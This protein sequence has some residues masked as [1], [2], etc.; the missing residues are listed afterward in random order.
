MCRS[1]FIPLC[2]YCRQPLPPVTMA[3]TAAGVAPVHICQPQIHVAAAAPD[4]SP[5]VVLNLSAGVGVVVPC[6]SGSFV[7]PPINWP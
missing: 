7:I 6:P 4:L 1:G 5:S 2:H 3:H